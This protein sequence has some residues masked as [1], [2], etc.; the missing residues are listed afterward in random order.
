M[1]Y[2]SDGLMLISKG[3]STGNQHGEWV[4]NTEDTVA[5][6]VA[7]DDYITDAKKRGMM[8]GDE[9]TI[10]QWGDSGNGNAA[11]FTSQYDRGDVIINYG[12]TVVKAINT[13][14]EANLV[15]LAIDGSIA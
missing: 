4:L 1:A 6:I 5:T 9:V 7:D 12:K 13:D 3:F 2:K 11:K 15:A 10:K 14:G 8:V